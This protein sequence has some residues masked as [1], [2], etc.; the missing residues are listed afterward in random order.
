MGKCTEQ[1]NKNGQV[2]IWTEVE[3]MDLRPRL[4][5][6]ASEH[7]PKEFQQMPDPKADAIDQT[8]IEGYKLMR[9][10][11]AEGYRQRDFLS[12]F[13]TPA[14]SPPVQL[15]LDHL[16]AFVRYFITKEP[17]ENPGVL[18]KTAQET[19]PTPENP[20]NKSY[21]NTQE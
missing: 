19:T 14:P 3:E 11:M 4:L 21:V 18:S 7:Y 8:V 15:D 20:T 13:D 5:Q 6:H 16:K 17:S 9:K 12:I 10:R 2:I 1:T